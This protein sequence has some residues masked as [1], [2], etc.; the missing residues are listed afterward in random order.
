MSKLGCDKELFYKKS[1][2]PSGMVAQNEG[3]FVVSYRGDLA[4]WSWVDLV[5]FDN[6]PLRDSSEHGWSWTVSKGLHLP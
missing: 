6:V 3:Y 2:N 1:P 5:D 4:R